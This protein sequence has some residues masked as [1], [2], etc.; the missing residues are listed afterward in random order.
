MPFDLRPHNDKLYLSYV[1]PSVLS[2][3]NVNLQRIK[4][5]RNIFIQEKLIR[6]LTFDPG[7]A[8]DGFGQCRVRCVF[9]I[10]QFFLFILTSTNGRTTDR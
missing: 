4:E 9:S 7:L 3:S 6:R 2:L 5:V 10:G 8:L 1:W